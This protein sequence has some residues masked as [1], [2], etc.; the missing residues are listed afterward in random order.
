M[1]DKIT[2]PSYEDIRARFDQS[3]SDRAINVL[4]IFSGHSRSDS[5]IILDELDRRGWKLVRN[6]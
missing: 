6:T 3:A 1:S 2:A 4:S 5:K